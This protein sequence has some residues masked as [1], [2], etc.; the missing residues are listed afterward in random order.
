MKCLREEIAGTAVW[1]PLMGRV[2][3]REVSVSGGSTAVSNRTWCRTIQGVIVFVI[4]NLPRSSRSSDIEI[5]RA[6]TP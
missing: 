1:C 5:T 2:R 4:S 3:L 6:I